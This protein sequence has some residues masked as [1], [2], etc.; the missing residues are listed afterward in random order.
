MVPF[1]LQNPGSG[2]VPRLRAD[3]QNRSGLV[4]SLRAD[5][6]I[7]AAVGSSVMIALIRAP[8]NAPRSAGTLAGPAPTPTV[9]RYA[10]TVTAVNPSGDSFTLEVQSDGA[11]Q[12]QSVVADVNSSTTIDTTAGDGTGP[13]MLAHMAVGDSARF[14]TDTPAGTSPALAVNVYDDGSSADPESGG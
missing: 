3:D 1:P 10:G 11:L 6:R 5:P 12:G 13:S 2:L 7:A 4:K 14:Y 8:C 9:T